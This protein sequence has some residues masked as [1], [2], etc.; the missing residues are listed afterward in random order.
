MTWDDDMDDIA[1]LPLRSGLWAHQTSKDLPHYPLITYDGFLEINLD[2]HHRS[3]T[4]FL[5]QPFKYSAHDCFDV[6]N[7]GRRWAGLIW[8]VFALDVCRVSDREAI[9]VDQEDV[10]RMTKPITVSEL[11]VLL[12]GIAKLT[13]RH[14]RLSR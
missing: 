10:D 11:S 6:R 5:P 1:K 4:V 3:S 2:C 7:R 12:L 14:P 13:M 8:G 9:R